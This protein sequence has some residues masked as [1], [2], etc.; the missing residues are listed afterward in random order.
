MT[1]KRVHE[2]RH[3]IYSIDNIHA[4]EIQK[5]LTSMFTKYM[6]QTNIPLCMRISLP[7]LNSQ[8]I[9][10]V[11]DHIVYD[12]S[13]YPYI[14]KYV[15]SSREKQK[16]KINDLKSHVS[17]YIIQINKNSKTILIFHAVM[18]LHKYAFKYGILYDLLDIICKYLPL[19]Y[20]VFNVENIINKIYFNK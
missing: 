19:K 14:E 10:K 4:N 18:T 6:K 7:L 17:Q 11:T 20:K 9:T 1:Y 8:L 15:V 12:F 13:I 2:T 3:S 5:T 16:N